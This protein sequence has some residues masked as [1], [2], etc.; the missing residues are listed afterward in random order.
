MT[1]KFQ[2]EYEENGSVKVTRKNHKTQVYKIPFSNLTPK[3]VGFEVKNPFVVYILFARNYSGKDYIYVGKSKNGIFNRPKS[4]ADKFNAEFCYILTQEYSGTFLNDGTIQYLENQVN[5]RVTGC[6]TFTNTTETTNTGTANSS[7]EEDCDDYLEEVYEMLQVL[8]LD[9]T[10]IFE[11]ENVVVKTEE[12]TK[13]SV[14]EL[15]DEELQLPLTALVPVAMRKLE[16]AGVIFTDEQLTKFQDAKFN[17]ELFGKNSKYPFM[18][19]YDPADKKCHYINGVPRFK[20][21]IYT[22]NGKRYL[23]SK[24][25]YDYQRK[26]FINWYNSLGL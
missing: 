17:L 7:D 9:L 26:G 18:K 4:H 20:K 6:N 24:E 8:G 21:D 22:F 12:P 2:I 5:K 11:E 19:A 15:T 25:W 23:V 3:K 13:P 16:S 10:T 1:H 14:P